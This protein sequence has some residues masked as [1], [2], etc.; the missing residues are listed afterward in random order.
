VAG[1]DGTSLSV[2]PGLVDQDHDRRCHLRLLH[3]SVRPAALVHPH[4]AL[5]YSRFTVLSALSPVFC[6]FLAFRFLTAIGVGAEYSAVNAAIGELIP[7]RC[8]GRAAAM[9]NFWPVG[10]IPA[11]L[12]ALYFISVAFGRIGA[13]IAPPALVAVAQHVSAAAAF[14]LLGG[15][16]LLGIL[17][18]ILWSLWGAEGKRRPLEMLAEP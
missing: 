6:A 15:F 17:A 4:T 11:R 8:R 7:A 14:A 5:I 10:T 13:T 2:D 1:L 18:M 9:M 3:G 12:I 16:W